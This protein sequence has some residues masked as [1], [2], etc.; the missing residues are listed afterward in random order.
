MA[1]ATPP[2]R[3]LDY[4]FLL[5]GVTSFIFGLIFLVRQEEALGLLMVV[6]GLWWLIQGIFML[7][8][9]FIDS[10]DAGWKVAIGVLGVVAGI[11][12]IA[13]PGEATDV[14][15]GAAGVILGILGI[16]IGL[17]ALAGA[18]RGAGFGAGLF[19]VIS[20]A[21]GILVLTNASFSTTV[22]INVFAIVLMIQGVGSVVMA[23]RD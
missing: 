6:L 21:L 13:N 15:K 7:F 8:A 3:V 16:L 9:V 20:I 11:L 14:F 4:A 5:G 22:L 1:L 18:M 10:S 19:G 17:S 23:L 2:E 12:V